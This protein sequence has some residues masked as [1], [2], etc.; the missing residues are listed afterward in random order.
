MRTV[1]RHAE[2]ADYIV[3]MRSAFLELL[4]PIRSRIRPPVLITPAAP[5]LVADLVVTLGLSQTACF[6]F[7][8]YQAERLGDELREFSADADVL[9][10]AD[11]WDVPGRFNTVLLPSPPRGERELKRDL[12]EQAYHVLE[13]GGRLVVLSPV[14]RDHFY[15]DLLKKTFGKVALE[16][17][18]IGTVLWSARRGD[19]PRRRHEMT[20]HVRDGEQSL[21]FMS[22]PGVFGYGRMDDG[23]RALT[24]VMQVKPGDRILDLGCGLGAVGILAARRGGP[25]ARVT[26]VDSNLR[27][28]A[29][30]GQNARANG[31]AVFEAIA[32]VRLEG[33]PERS[34]DLALANP[35]YYAQHGVARLF[36]EG[37]RRMLVPGGRLHLVT[38]QAD[39][40]SE[41]VAEFFGQPAVEVRRGYSVLTAQRR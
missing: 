12:V 14:P 5:R 24:D 37:A 26:L 11:L 27:A 4:E 2:R 6:Q 29:L 39:V 13:E 19:K 7:D 34:F 17:S 10:A 38:K 1:L 3:L 8:L 18:G 25:E 22:R 40:V 31:L 35:P 36:L 20:F 28:V 41:I 16:R 15:P 32:A 23:S 33:L 9:T 21:V 30:A